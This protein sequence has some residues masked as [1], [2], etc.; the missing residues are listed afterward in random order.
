MLREIKQIFSHKPVLDREA[1][2]TYY[3]RL[4]EKIDI[5]WFRDGNFIIGDIKTEDHHFKTQGVSVDN[6]IE[7][8]NDSLYTV[9]NIPQD[10]LKALS[11]AKSYEPDALSLEKL[12]NSG[13]KQSEIILQ[14]QQV[15]PA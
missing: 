5:K 9:Y 10:Y 11:K 7:M 14:K 4:P 2:E 8:V 1:F 12:N 6:F 13:V 3:N 15:K